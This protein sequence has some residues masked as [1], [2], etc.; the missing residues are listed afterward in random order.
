MLEIPGALA[1]VAPLVGVEPFAAVGALA[2]S[3]LLVAVA[4]RGSV[5]KGATVGMARVWKGIGVGKTN[6][7]TVKT[8]A[9]L[10]A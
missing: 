9:V 8:V 10:V 3:G 1:I 4:T 5:G 2:G 7:G 6:V